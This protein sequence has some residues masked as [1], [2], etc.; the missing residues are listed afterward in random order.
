ME[1]IKGGIYLEVKK[2]VIGTGH[3]AKTEEFRNFWMTITQK[4]D[5]VQC[6]LLDNDFK[7]T[8]LRETIP[9]AVLNGERFTYIPQ[10]EKRYR[11][12]LAQ[13]AEAAAKKQTAPPPAP[14]QAK[15]EKTAS[16]KWW[17]GEEKDV[18]PGDLFKRDE[19]GRSKPAPVASKN[20]WEAG[21]KEATTEDI[22]KKPED[23]GKKSSKPRK[24]DTNKV[25]KK[26]WWDK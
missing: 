15:P 6:I 9:V 19:S 21:Q 26:T 11:A 1:D 25:I 14:A 10:G 20:W 23:S 18:K 5:E 24:A 22:F 4:G 12:I 3:T 16:P 13:L 7:P 17:Q 8:G 2:G